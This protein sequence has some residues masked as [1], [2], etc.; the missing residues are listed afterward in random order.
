MGNRIRDR[1]RHATLL[2]GQGRDP[3]TL[4]WLY[5][6]SPRKQLLFSNNHYTTLIHN[7]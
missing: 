2:K 3:K 7:Y 4:S 1:W 5:P 6:I